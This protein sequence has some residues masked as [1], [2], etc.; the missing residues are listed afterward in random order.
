MI[1][2]NAKDPATDAKLKAYTKTIEDKLKEAHIR[3]TI[4][5][6]NDKSLGFRL[7]VYKRQVL[8]FCLLV[9]L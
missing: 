8:I 4:E 1:T 5:D 3:Y 6:D 7:D 2:I 9:D